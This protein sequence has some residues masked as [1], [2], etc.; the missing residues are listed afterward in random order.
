M[1]TQQKQLHKRIGAEI[2][3][4]RRSRDVTQEALGRRIRLSRTSVT[5][6]ESGRQRTS[7]DVL[8]AIARTLKTLPSD[9]VR[10]AE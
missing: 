7:L 8:F 1:T 9:I 10:C 2:H 6:I 3:R 5:N 4:L